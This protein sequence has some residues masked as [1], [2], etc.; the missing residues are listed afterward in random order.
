MNN[1]CSLE[2][3][4]KQINLDKRNTYGTKVVKIYEN[5]ILYAKQVKL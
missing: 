2:D 3:D 5:N 4:L 1:L